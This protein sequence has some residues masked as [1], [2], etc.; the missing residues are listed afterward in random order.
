MSSDSLI[1][2]DYRVLFT[3]VRER[4]RSAQYEA[5][6]AVNRQLVE[7]YRDIGGMIVES[8]AT[9]PGAARRS[10]GCREISKPSFRA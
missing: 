1:R 8:S 5:L 7:L 3:A 9:S 6:R 10:S 4:I 2:E